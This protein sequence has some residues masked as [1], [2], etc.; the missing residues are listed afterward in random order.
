M[1][2]A[3]IKFGN[4]T[5]A[6]TD[7]QRLNCLV[8]HKDLYGDFYG[9]GSGFDFARS[10][11]VP[12]VLYLDDPVANLVAGADPALGGLNNGNGTPKTIDVHANEGIKFPDTVEIKLP[13]DF[14]LFLLGDTPSARVSVWFDHYAAETTT[15]RV[16][17]AG[18]YNHGTFLQWAISASDTVYAVNVGSSGSNQ[19]VTFPVT[20]GETLISILWLKNSANGFNAYIYHDD[21]LVGTISRLYPL[22]NPADGGGSTIPSLGGSGGLTGAA[23]V[24]HRRIEV[25][26]VDPATYTV[27]DHEAWIA[28]QIALNGPRFA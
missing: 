17:G 25:Q 9:G 14:N 18:G 26:P 13:D 4:F 5:A 24:V 21:E 11:L 15:K 1:A 16:A 19:S 2:N 10:D 22:N 3:V 6:L 12:D 28:D 7:T 20:T 8:D 27:E 23:K